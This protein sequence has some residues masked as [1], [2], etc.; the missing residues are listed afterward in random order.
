MNNSILQTHPGDLVHILFYDHCTDSNQDNPEPLL[1]EV[2]GW[3]TENVR[4]ALNDFITVKTSRPADAPN[5][6]YCNCDTFTILSCAI[7]SIT[8]LQADPSS[9]SDSPPIKKTTPLANPAGT[10]MSY[11]PEFNNERQSTEAEQ[12]RT[13]TQRCCA[14]PPEEP[15]A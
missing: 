5:E 12:V 13:N 11:G 14:E 8:R 3:V 7:V 4:L 2:V 10:P 9:P 1:L 15:N 6:D